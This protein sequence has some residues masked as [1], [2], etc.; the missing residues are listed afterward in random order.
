MIVRSTGRR[1]PDWKDILKYLEIAEIDFPLMAER[2][3]LHTLKPVESTGL[4]D[5][6]V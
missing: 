5:E 2:Q 1:Q 3:A 4:C 6:T